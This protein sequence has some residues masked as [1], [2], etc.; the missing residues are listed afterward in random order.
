MA[1]SSDG[2]TPLH[3]AARSGRKEIAEL[4]ID[5]GAEV[6]AK[7]DGGMTPLHPAAACRSQRN[8][9]TSYRQRC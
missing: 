8:R 5:K 2:S 1:K 4:L 6:N 9:R 7:E 3:E